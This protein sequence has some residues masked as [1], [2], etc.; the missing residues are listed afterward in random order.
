MRL[1]PSSV[2]LYTGIVL[3]ILNIIV[4]SLAL[5]AKVRAPEQQQDSRIGKLEEDVKEI[6]AIISTNNS[7]MK[8]FFENDDKRISMLENAQTINLQ[9]LS[10]LLSHGINGNNIEEM[11]QAKSELDKFLYHK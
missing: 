8:T 5:L 3:S 11:R 1:D 6:R 4:I 2:S 9:A 7:N 10:A